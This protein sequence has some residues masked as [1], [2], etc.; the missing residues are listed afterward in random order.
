MPGAKL[1]ECVLI[2][3]VN[4]EG[5]G[6][7]ISSA[8]VNEL[9]KWEMIF[10]ICRVAVVID[11]VHFFFALNDRRYLSA[12]RLMEQQRRMQTSSDCVG[13]DWLSRD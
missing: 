6:R 11:W 1:F 10:A 13:L 8:G 9:L 3:H 12:E 5:C 7:L 4:A 2:F